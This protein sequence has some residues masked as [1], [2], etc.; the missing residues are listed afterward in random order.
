MREQ[1]T[2]QKDLPERGRYNNGTNVEPVLNGIVQRSRRESQTTSRFSKAD[3]VR[4]Y[5]QQ[6]RHYV[7]KTSSTSG[8][9]TNAGSLVYSGLAM[10]IAF[11]TLWTSFI[12]AI[13][14]G[15]NLILGLL[16]AALRK[17]GRSVRRAWRSTST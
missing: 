17:L 4:Y 5:W 7:V 14:N 13:L 1:C 10:L 12:F 3:G 15:S 11:V 9:S 16:I 6:V 8:L 2:L